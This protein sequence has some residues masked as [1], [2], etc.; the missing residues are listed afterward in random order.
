MQLVARLLEAKV[1]F[2]A[3]FAVNDET[4]IGAIRGLEEAGLRVPDDVRVVGFDDI[5][6]A[7]WVRPALTTVQASPRVLGRTATEV[8]IARIRGRPTALETRIPTSLVIRA[9]CGCALEEVPAP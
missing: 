1:A 2:E 3:V 5:G 4:A 6:M 8:L 9:S 7:A